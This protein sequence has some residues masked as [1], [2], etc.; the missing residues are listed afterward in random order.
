M[1]TLYFTYSDVHQHE[2]FIAR[3]FATG[4]EYPKVCG[5][6]EATEPAQIVLDNDRLKKGPKEKRILHV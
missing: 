3:V 1:L 5:R 2:H 4:A 6:A